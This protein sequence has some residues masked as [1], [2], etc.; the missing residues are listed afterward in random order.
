MDAYKQKLRRRIWWQAAGALAGLVAAVLSF[1]LPIATLDADAPEF[2][3][4]FVS[5]FAFGLGAVY[6][7]LMLAGI[8]RVRRA[9]ANEARLKAMYTEETDERNRMIREKVGETG[10]SLMLNALFVAG[11]FAVYFS[12]TVS[13]TLFG[14]LAVM[15]LM[16]GGLRGYYRQKY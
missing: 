8:M 1:V 4:G 12:V 11:L 2:L 15:A 14:V 3:R 9:L 16:M 7:V 5:G 6:V 10:F 13:V